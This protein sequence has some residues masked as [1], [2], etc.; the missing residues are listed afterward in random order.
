[1][2]ME[3]KLSKEK[4]NRVQQ[5]VEDAFEARL[6]GEKDYTLKE[7]KEMIYKMIEKEN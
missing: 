3:R 6:A 1:M 7:S 4:D 5:L 2:I